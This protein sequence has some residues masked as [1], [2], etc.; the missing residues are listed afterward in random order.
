MLARQS[1]STVSE[2]VRTA[3]RDKYVGGAEA[4]KEALLSA[5]G[6]WKDGTDISDA[7]AY[8]GRL[9]RGTRLDRL[10]K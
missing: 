7:K 2:L 3:V 9:R 1:H 5:V 8:V 4:R 10:S 6:L